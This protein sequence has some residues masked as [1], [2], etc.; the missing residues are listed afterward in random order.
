MGQLAIHTSSRCGKL[1]LII[2]PVVVIFFSVAIV[3]VIATVVLSIVVAGR[4]HA[5]VGFAM[6]ISRN[7]FVLLLVLLLGLSF[8]DSAKPRALG[9]HGLA[10]WLPEQHRGLPNHKRR[11]IHL[12][13][14]LPKNTIE[15]K[16]IGHHQA[17]FLNGLGV[18][19]L[20]SRD[21]P[22]QPKRH[23]KILP[24]GQLFFAG[25]LA[26]HA[27]NVCGP[28]REAGRTRCTK[29]PGPG[30]F[31]SNVNYEVQCC[32][33]HKNDRV[34]NLHQ[35]WP[36]QGSACQL[37]RVKYCICRATVVKAR[38]QRT[39]VAELAP[40]PFEKIEH[41]FDARDVS[42]SRAVNMGSF[43]LLGATV[44]PN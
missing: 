28:R 6:I 15:M 37:D 3:V 29:C 25:P 34:G 38:D 35:P 27:K 21:L 12:G 24:Y 13:R 41:G 31:W 43:E 10:L 5:S 32:A 22:T 1:Q 23:R 19:L 2:F 33:C 17:E 39:V 30:V 9:Q 11:H 42:L 18:S 14:T 7:R 44:A 26:D 36:V 4:C 20:A 40:Q 16:Q 8:G